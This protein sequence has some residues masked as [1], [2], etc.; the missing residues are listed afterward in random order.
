MG[1]RGS[2]LEVPIKIFQNLSYET[3][4]ENAGHVMLLQ[5]LSSL[6]DANFSVV[7]DINTASFEH[8]SVYP[9]PDIHY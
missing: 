5:T 3:I 1:S 4:H 2:N 6:Q 9:A 7:K 8:I